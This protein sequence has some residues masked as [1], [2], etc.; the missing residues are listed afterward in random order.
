M[1]FYVKSNDSDIIDDGWTIEDEDGVVLAHVE[2]EG[3]AD[4]L[5]T[6]LLGQAAPPGGWPSD[7]EIADLAE[8][9]EED[10][11]EDDD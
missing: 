3:M 10:E 9:D 4:A 7:C 6:Y 8:D 1:S 5:L 2:T 11:E